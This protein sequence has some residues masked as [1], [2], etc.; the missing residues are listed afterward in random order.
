MDAD[1]DGFPDEWEKKYGLNP[2]DPNDVNL[3]K[4]GDGF[5]NLEEFNAKTDPSDPKDHPD[6]LD[7]LKLQLPLKETYV[8][9][10]FRKANK[11]PAGWRIEIVDPKERDDYGRAG[12]TFSVKVGEDVVYKD[13]KKLKDYGYTLKAY[14]PKSVKQKIQGTEGHTKTIDVS[15]ITVERKTDKRQVTFAIQA[16]KNPP[17]APIDVQATLVY[18]RGETKN[19][20]VI[21]GSTIEL[22]GSKYKVL[23]ISPQGKGASITLEDHLGRKKNLSARD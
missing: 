17:L 7:S 9:F 10:A 6:Y 2:S 12:R 3:D 20:D 11:I 8:P 14:E 21:A 22:N 19:F 13:G 5:T 18:T 1:G 23:S 4:D 16:G 15:E